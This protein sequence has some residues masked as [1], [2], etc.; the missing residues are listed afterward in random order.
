M[1]KV[2][3]DTFMLSAYLIEEDGLETA[4]YEAL[5]KL[6]QQTKLFETVFA[7]VDQRMAMMIVKEVHRG[8]YEQAQVNCHRCGLDFSVAQLCELAQFYR[9]I[10]GLDVSR[11]KRTH[12]SL[13]MRELPVHMEE[14]CTCFR[15]TE[16][17][18][19]L[20]DPTQETVEFLRK[21]NPRG[22]ENIIVETFGCTRCPKV[23]EIVLSEV[24]PVLYR[25]LPWVHG[26]RK[27]CQNCFQASQQVRQSSRPP[28]PSNPR[29]HP[30]SK[31]PISNTVVKHTDIETLQQ[32]VAQTLSPAGE[33]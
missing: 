29:Q 12:C 2:H 8:A 14:F 27:F 19:W 32:L 24:T 3:V 4:S 15:V 30:R 23:Q 1:V 22:W 10:W 7:G 17:G 18:V 9:N 6:T 11:E 25:G 5:V 13:C 31:G 20:R 33:S 28:Q 21:K 26:S 16:I